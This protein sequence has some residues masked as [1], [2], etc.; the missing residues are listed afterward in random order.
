LK[1]VFILAGKRVVFIEFYIIIQKNIERVDLM[2]LIRGYTN[3]LLELTSNKINV[4]FGVIFSA[5][6]SWYSFNFNREL[7][8][9]ETFI[10]LSKYYLDSPG[11]Y[12]GGM[13]LN[14][15]SSIIVLT[16]GISFIYFSIRERDE[17]QTWYLIFTAIL[18]LGLVLT[19]IYFLGYFFLLLLTLIIIAIGGLFIVKALEENRK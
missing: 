13:F 17:Y 9:P 11:P 3:I 18:G 1:I 5:I 14:L 12:L 7:P 8:K 4:L 10:E 19:T 16:L 6:I 15:I 2:P